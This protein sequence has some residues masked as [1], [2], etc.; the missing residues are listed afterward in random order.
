ML[1]VIQKMEKFPLSY[2]VN[3]QKVIVEDQ[4]LTWSLVRILKKN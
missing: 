2:E 3:D 1:A 4:R